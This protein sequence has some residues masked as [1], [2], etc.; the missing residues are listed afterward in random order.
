MTVDTNQQPHIDRGHQLS[1]G[2]EDS[3]RHKVLWIILGIVLLLAVVLAVVLVWR[4]LDAA[5]KVAPPPPKITIT[6]ATAKK[7]D[8][9]VYLD[10][11]GT[12][13][14]VYTASISSQVNGLVVTV[15]YKE[16]Q[17]VRKGDPLS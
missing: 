5:K 13:T 1:T 15:H 9:G 11:I 17:L 6:T 14:P 10:S 2:G 8:I 12:V 16:G 4:H 7:G 3:H